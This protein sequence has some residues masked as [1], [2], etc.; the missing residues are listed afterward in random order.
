M[1]GLFRVFQAA[2]VRRIAYVLVG[3]AVALVVT[4]WDLL[5]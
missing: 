4:L 3:L 1:N 2:V 5:S